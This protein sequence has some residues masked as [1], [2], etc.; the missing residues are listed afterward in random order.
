MSQRHGVLKEQ[1]ENELQFHLTSR[2]RATGRR[3][4]R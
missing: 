2:H 4:L 3:N 1:Y